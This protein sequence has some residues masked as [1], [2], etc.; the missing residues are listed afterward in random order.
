MEP[1]YYRGPY[2][3]KVVVFTENN[4]R[5]LTNPENI[6]YYRSLPNVLIDPDLKEVQRVPPHLWVKDGNFVRVMS[7]SASKERISHIQ[8]HGAKN[9]FHSAPAVLPVVLPEKQIIPPIP[10]WRVLN[11]L[12]L[13]CINLLQRLEKWTY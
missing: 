2:S 6:E 12:V 5:V 13:K 3:V 10:K 1:P 8:R 7:K 11:K 9:H 4:A